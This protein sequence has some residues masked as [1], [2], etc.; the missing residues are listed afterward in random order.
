VNHRVFAALTYL[1]T[2]CM[3]QTQRRFRCEFM[4]GRIPSRDAVS[5][6]IDSFVGGGSAGCAS[7]VRTPENAE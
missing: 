2:K 5:K 6:W 7:S 4:H 1:E 3:M